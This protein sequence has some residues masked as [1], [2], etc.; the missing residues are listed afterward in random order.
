MASILVR[1]LDDAVKDQ[2]A[3]QA[4]RRGH[5]MEAE[6]REILTGAVQ[7]P[8]IGVALMHAVQE[9]GGVDDLIVP[10]RMDA[11]RAVGFEE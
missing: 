3:R 11:A 8:N 10:R 5:S 7:L 1:G 4:K 2:L 6:A 9:V